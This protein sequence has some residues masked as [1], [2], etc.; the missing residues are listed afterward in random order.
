MIRVNGRKIRE[1]KSD[2][3]SI[4]I[5]NHRI[6]WSKRYQRYTIYDMKRKRQI[7]DT[8]YY[9]DAVRFVLQN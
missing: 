3:D 8:E 4:Q 5:N 7:Y 6:R 2:S 9:R 1:L